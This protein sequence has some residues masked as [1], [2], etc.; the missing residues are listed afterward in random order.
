MFPVLISKN[1]IQTKTQLHHL[2]KI[3][4]GFSKAHSG[5]LPG[6]AHLS[7][8]VTENSFITAPLD[9]AEDIVLAMDFSDMNMKVYNSSGNEVWKHDFGKAPLDQVYQ[10]FDDTIT[11]LGHTHKVDKP[12]SSNQKLDEAVAK[13]LHKAYWGI[14]KAFADVRKRLH[15]E[16]DNIML[17]PHHFD[18]A[19]NWYSGKGEGEEAEMIY[20]GFSSGDETDPIPYF[21]LYRYPWDENF[22]PSVEKPAQFHQKNWKGIFL[23]YN[24]FLEAAKDDQHNYLVDFIV[25]SH[26]ELT[27]STLALT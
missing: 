9:R 10:F 5:E 16:P 21:A 6:W 7:V 18:L 27:R 23:D 19:F 15:T 13:D 20:H 14:H 4:G 26:D 3:L 17:W 25:S 12:E 2:L 8:R 24:D 11:N 22:K 1:Y